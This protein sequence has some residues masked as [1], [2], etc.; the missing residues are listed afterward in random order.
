MSTIAIIGAGAS[1][2]MAAITAA[3]DSENRVLLFERQA[4]AGRKLLSTGN[5][6]CNLTNEGMTQE[7]AWCVRAV[8]AAQYPMYAQAEFRAV[9]HVLLAQTEAEG[10][11]TDSSRVCVLYQFAD[12]VR[13]GRM[14]QPT[15]SRRDIAVMDMTPTADGT[16]QC[17]AFYDAKALS[18]DPS[19]A[20]PFQDVIQG[21]QEL[22]HTLAENCLAQAQAYARKQG[23]N[24]TVG[25]LQPQYG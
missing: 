19:I 22:Y 10:T 6:R 17:T 24:V 20:E 18:D 15:Q 11:P 1:G 21:S 23:E 13:E 8:L 16:L 25:I 2:M 14:L 3:E 12:Y 5:G 4:R 9:S 7:I